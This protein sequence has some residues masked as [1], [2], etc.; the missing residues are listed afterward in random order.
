M[1]SLYI[2]STAGYSGK[3]MVCLGLGTRF[4]RDGFHFSYMKPIGK[5]T[6]QVGDVITDE[7]AI[8]IA[9]ALSLREPLDTICPIVVTQDM[10]VQA[11]RNKTEGLEGKLI[12][13]HLKLSEGRDIMLVGGGSDLYEGAFLGLSGLYIAQKLLNT[14]V[15][16]IDRFTTEVCVDCILGVKEA[17]KE[18]LIGVI[19]NRVAPER[20][21]YVERR[22]APFLSSRGIDTFGIIPYDQ[23]LNAVTVKELGS[24]LN[25]EVL[26]CNDRL[27]ELVESYTIGAMTVDRALKYFRQKKNKAVITGGDRPEIQLAA[28]ETSTKCIILTGNLYPSDLILVQAEEHNV[29]VMVAK[30]DTQATVEKVERIFGR[31]RVRDQRKVNRAVELI[32]QRIDFPLLYK[33]IGLA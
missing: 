25:A 29:P 15:I 20:I 21:E 26:C 4:A 23:L 7:D 6:A 18:R 3:S 19:L 17:L 11:Y 27:D 1:I 5:P 32:D 12:E 16:L 33:K 13:A 22:I 24:T 31:I 28:L 8:F 14:Q 9:K 10:I 2:G 30:D